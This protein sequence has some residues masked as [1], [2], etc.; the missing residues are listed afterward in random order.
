MPDGYNSQ[1]NDYPS[2]DHC[3]MSMDQKTR[4]DASYSI[5]TYKYEQGNKQLISDSS[6]QTWEN[7]RPY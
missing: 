7:R 4:V 2:R 5:W 6:Y 1:S 3:I